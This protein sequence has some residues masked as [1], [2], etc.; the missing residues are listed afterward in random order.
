MTLYKNVHFFFFF[1]DE[2]LH[3]NTFDP[4]A[5]HRDWCPWISVGKEN[6]DPGTIPLLG[7]DV[8]SNQQG[9]KVALD[10]LVPIKISNSAGSSPA[11]ASRVSCSKD[12]ACGRWD[13]VFVVLL[14]SFLFFFSS[15]VHVTSL[16]G[17]LL[18][19]DSGRYPLLHHHRSRLSPIGKSNVTQMNG[20]T[21]PHFVAVSEW[22]IVRNVHH[23]IR[24]CSHSEFLEEKQWGKNAMHLLFGNQKYVKDAVWHYIVL[25]HQQFVSN[26]ERLVLCH[27]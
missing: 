27:A 4:L 13:C 20:L 9:W 14:R 26:D 1:Q 3:K 2:L 11:Q 19:S 8:A 25:F 5:Q 22:H 7:E 24:L 10:L 16:K 15:R 6:V 18:Y 17:C 21:Y 23:A 12:C